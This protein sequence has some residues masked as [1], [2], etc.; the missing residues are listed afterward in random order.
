MGAGQN[1]P[2]IFIWGFIKA[3]EIKERHRQN[4]FKDDPALTRRLVRRMLVRDWK[5]SF[6][7]QL[8]QIDTYEE[9]IVYLQAKVTENH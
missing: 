6:K 5:Q 2:G 1:I 4:Q 3:W 8:E 9:H 7:A